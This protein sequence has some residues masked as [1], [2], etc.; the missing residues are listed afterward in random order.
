VINL[1]EH[2]I[3]MLAIMVL[4]VLN[5]TSFALIIAQA[6]EFVIL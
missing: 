4:T 1:M 5:N 6:T 2:V 3:V